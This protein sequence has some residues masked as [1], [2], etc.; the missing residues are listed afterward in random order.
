M[1]V[2]DPEKKIVQLL[3]KR[4]DSTFRQS[5]ALPKTLHLFE[6][7]AQLIYHLPSGNSNP[8]QAAPV[9]SATSVGSWAKEHFRMKVLGK[10]AD[11]SPTTSIWASI[12][13]KQLFHR[14]CRHIFAWEPAEC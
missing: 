8:L 10:Q 12:G 9:C 4:Q 7:Q 11:K 6:I 5:K 3:P 2:E 13:A 14:E 1:Q